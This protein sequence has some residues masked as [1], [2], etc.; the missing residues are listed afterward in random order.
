MGWLAGGAT[1]VIRRQTNLGFSFQ[2]GRDGVAGALGHVV[3][4]I[5]DKAGRALRVE[6][7]VLNTAVLGCGKRVEKL[8]EQLRCIEY[9]YEEGGGG[10]FGYNRYLTGI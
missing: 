10:S 7:K 1:H 2:L 8:G 5:Y 3:L 4:K 9:E 6:V